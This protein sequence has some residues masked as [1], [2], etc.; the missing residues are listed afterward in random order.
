MP[1]HRTLVTVACVACSI[2]VSACAGDPQHTAS[3]TAPTLQASSATAPLMVQVDKVC[4]GRESEIR[5]FVDAL[6]I[7][8]TN[9]GE[10]GVSRMVTIG[11]HLLSAISKRGTLWG[12]YPAGVTAA[13]RVERLG[14]LPPDAI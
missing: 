1:G 3:L 4:A 6:P 13:G 8:V 10:P 9:P 12:P 11:D 14:C 7:G 5:V 2:I